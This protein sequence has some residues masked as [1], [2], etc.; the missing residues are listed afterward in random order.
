MMRH[1]NLV[2]AVVAA[3]IIAALGAALGRRDD[4]LLAP[5]V[6]V[7]RYGDTVMVQVP[8]RRDDIVRGARI[9]I[10]DVVLVAS[11]PVVP[12]RYGNTNVY[13]PAPEGMGERATVTVALDTGET[14]TRTVRVTQGRLLEL[15][16]GAPDTMRDMPDL[17]GPGDRCAPVAAADSLIAMAKQHG[18]DAKLPA[19][20][21]TV[22]AELS[23]DMQWSPARGVS[24][25]AFV[26]GANLWSQ[27]KGLPI[28][29]TMVGAANGNGTLSAVATASSAQL[30]L[31]WRDAS[32]MRVGAH[33]VALERVQLMDGA[34]YLFIRD[35]LSPPGVDVYRINGT[36]I[37]DY[38]YVGHAGTI[39]RGFV[40]TW[41]A[42][43]DN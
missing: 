33:A 1:R 4:R 20:P 42:T 15:K 27:K 10:D 24:A 14:V 23:D 31:V 32:G 17:A 36:E 37:V 25:P 12:Q 21:D 34:Q 2:I 28:R 38:P 19:M 30:E 16:P 26:A 29:T 43:T 35:P 39:G 5:Q 6:G 13:A 22:I 8:F 11:V 9:T 18:A 3:L 41:T 40:Q 7:T